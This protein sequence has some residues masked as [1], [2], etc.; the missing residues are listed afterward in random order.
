MS[1]RNNRR[2]GV[3]LEGIF[4][5]ADAIILKVGRRLLAERRVR[6]LIEL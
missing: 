3:T 1:R 6:T 2:H 4:G 5:S